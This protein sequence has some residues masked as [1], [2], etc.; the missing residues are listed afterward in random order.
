MPNKPSRRHCLVQLAWALATAH[1]TWVTGRVLAA[2]PPHIAQAI[3][4]RSRSLRLD[5]SGRA[6]I[7]VT[8][9][10]ID[11]QGELLAAAGDDNQIRLIDPAELTVQAT[12]AGHL[13]RIR[14]LTFDR[15]GQYLASA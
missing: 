14:T 10:A 11:S 9:V 8:A 15:T 13:D 3:P 5:G 4:I 1:P 6:G 7:V 12:L 2:E